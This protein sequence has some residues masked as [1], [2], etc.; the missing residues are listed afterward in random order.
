[1]TFVVDRD[2]ALTLNAGNAV[3]F[4][5]DYAG[6]PPGAP[7]DPSTVPSA[8]WIPVGACDQTG[9]TEGFSETTTNVMAIGILTPFRVLYTEQA[10]TF[11]VV[12][13]EAERDICQSVMFRVPLS[14]LTRTTGLRTV[15]DSPTPVPDRRAWLFRL[16]DGPTLQQFYVPVGEVTTRANVAY[17]QNDVAKFD[18]TLT[19]YPDNAGVTCYRLDNAPVTPAATNS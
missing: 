19:C 18:C 7:A 6:D 4:T 12:M 9:I 3:A 14:S 16:A 17:S 8:S 10:K 13:L 1:M 11:Q 15:A 5:V 2:E